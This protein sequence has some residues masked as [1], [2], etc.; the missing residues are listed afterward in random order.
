MSFFVRHPILS[1]YTT[2]VVGWAGAKAYAT[3]ELYRE[4]FNEEFQKD[5]VRCRERGKVLFRGV[6][7]SGVGAASESEA[8]WRGRIDEPGYCLIEGVFWPISMPITMLPLLKKS[9]FQNLGRDGMPSD[10]VTVPSLDQNSDLVPTSP[11]TG[12]H[13]F[14]SF[15]SDSRDDDS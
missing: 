3:G 8:V 6:G 7:V 2:G 15:T 9:F 12:T 4:R 14:D 1:T 5:P 13:R 10:R 11:L